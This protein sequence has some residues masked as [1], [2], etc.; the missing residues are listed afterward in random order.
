MNVRPVLLA[1]TLILSTAALADSSAVQFEVSPLRDGKVVSSPRVVAEFGK[2]VVLSQ[3]NA[4]RFEGSATAP[5]AEGN[6][7]ISV[8]LA[9]FENGAMKPA[10]E[11]SMLADLSKSPSIRYAVPGTNARFVV[12]PT[13]VKLPASKG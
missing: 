10:Q 4:M 6:S 7:R 2:S 3:A 13:L 5:D 8:K 12:R 11:M 9:P 1:A